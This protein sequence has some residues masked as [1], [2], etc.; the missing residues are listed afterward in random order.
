V[1]ERIGRAGGTAAPE[2]LV[3]D[4][5]AFFHDRLK[6]QLREQGARHDLVDAV[7]AAGVGDE[8]GAHRSLAVHEDDLLM[9]VRRVEAL[10]AFLSSEDG[11]N[12]LTG[13]RRAANILKAE[14]KK[15]GRTYH[16]RPRPELFR[17]Q[18]EI[19]L[20]AAIDT[21]R[22]EAEVAIVREDFAT[23][24]AALARLRAPVDA[25]FDKVLVNAEEPAVREN[26][27][28]LLNEIRSTTLA[29]ADFSKIQ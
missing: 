18:E 12:L 19:A 21:A 2:A 7:L 3:A 20:A 26:R 6:V 24:M 15:D 11:A 8:E 14:E 23:A 16:G 22:D 17:D 27:L 29:V 10:G 13:H 1:L 5:V 25:F 9:I 4:L 28:K